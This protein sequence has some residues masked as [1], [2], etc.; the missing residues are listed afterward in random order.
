MTNNGWTPERRKRQA[1]MI[2]N[3]KPWEQSTGPTTPEGKEARQEFTFNQVATIGKVNGYSRVPE[4]YARTNG[5][6]RRIYIEITKDLKQA[7]A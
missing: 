3:W 5:S 4:L 1:E 7:I 6:L 2:K